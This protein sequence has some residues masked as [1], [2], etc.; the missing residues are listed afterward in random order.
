MFAVKIY[1]APA[2]IDTTVAQWKQLGFDTIMVGRACLKDAAF[3][4]KLHEAGFALSVVEPLFLAD[5]GTAPFSDYRP[6]LFEDGSVAVD[7]WVRFVCPSDTAWLSK[8]Y[9]R[10]HNDAASGADIVTFDFARFFQFWEMVLPE[11]DEAA[12]KRTCSCD[13]CSAAASAF[14]S[15][16]EWRTG[17]ISSTVKKCSQAAHAAKSDI[18]TGVHIVP[19][20]TDMFGGALEGVLGQD[21]SELSN[22]VDFLAPMTYQHMIHQPPEYISE[23]VTNHRK[24]INDRI[25]VIPSVQIKEIYRTDVLARDE[26]RKAI[27]E[28]LRSSTGGLSFYQWTDIAESK[29]SFDIIKQELQPYL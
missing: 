12:L 27:Q 24:T 5:E 13:L 9:D 28:A 29:E 7:D 14:K 23:L 8:V 11:T 16:R 22:Y 21:L 10:I 19:W 3:I 18:R 1:A 15:G 20:K 6:A 2:D 17:V 4:E 25:P 26:F